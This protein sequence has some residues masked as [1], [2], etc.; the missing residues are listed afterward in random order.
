[1]ANSWQLKIVDVRNLIKKI[2]KKQIAA[3]SYEEK[4]KK[5]ESK[6]ICLLYLKY[7]LI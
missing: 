3:K 5:I 6:K 2:C 1:L 7:K 4:I